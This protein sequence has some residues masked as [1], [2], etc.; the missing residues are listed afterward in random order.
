MG[1][2]EDVKAILTEL[3]G[4]DGAKVLENFEDPKLYPK[5]FLEEVKH[6]L[7]DLLGEKEADEILESIYKKYKY[8]GIKK[9]E[10]KIYS[11]KTKKKHL[12]KFLFSLLI[13]DLI[14]NVKKNLLPFPTSL[15]TQIFPPSSFTN[16]LQID[17]P[18]P[19]PL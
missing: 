19:A 4:E 8:L 16:S 3:L 18:R 5:D 6:F 7:S 12:I 15:S 9:E 2:Y 1:L 14:G 17:K 10:R 13:Q 11:R